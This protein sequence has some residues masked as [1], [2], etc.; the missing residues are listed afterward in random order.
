MPM[1]KPAGS[2][3][4]ERKT[5]SSASPFGTQLKLRAS[6]A[7]I[8]AAIAVLSSG[9]ALAADESQDIAE[10]R[11][12]NAR[13]RQ[14]LEA[15]RE[16]ARQAKA[17]LAPA[18]AVAPADNAAAKPATAFKAAGADG[19]VAFDKVVITS[20][21]R[22]EIAQ[23][24]PLPIQVIGGAQLER[25]DVKSVWDLP[26]KAPNLR[27]NP[28]GENA[29]K[30]S[31]S[32]RGVG[33]NGA[34]DSAEGS[35][36]TIVDG[37]SLYYAGQ[38]WN[39]YVDLDRIEVLRGPQG[40]LMGKNTTL[41]AVN[42]VTKAPSFTPS[43]SFEVGTG[44]LNSLQGKFSATGPL[45]DGLLAY[46]GTFVVDRA[47]GLYTNTYQ[48]FGNAKE[49]WNETNRLAGRFQFLLTPS[50]DLSARFIFDKLRSDE[51]TNL[52]FQWDNGPNTWSDGVARSSVTVPAGA[53]GSFSRIGYLGKFTQRSAWF[54]NSDGTVYQPRLGSTN[55]GNSEARPQITNQYGSSA[56]VDWQLKDHTLTSIT[57]YR[58]QDFDIKNGG[59]YDQ[60]YI[61]NSGQQLWNKQFSQEF[62][63]ASTPAADKALDY[64]VGLYYLKARVYSDDPTY[65][66]ADAGAWNASSKDY[67]TLIANAAGRE[68]LRASLDGIYQSSVTDARVRSVA[69][70]GQADWHVTEQATLTAGVR[71]T[72]EHK[73]NRIS[74]QL[75]RPGQ[76]LA[77]LA[78]ANGAS[79]AQ[80]AAATATRNGQVNT[81]FDF[82][83]GLPI[84]DKLTAWNFGPSYK[85]SNDILLYSSVGKGVKSGIVAWKSTTDTT[86]SNLES[87]KSLDFEL[88]FK[89]LLLDRKVQFNVNLYQTKITDYQTQVSVLQSD[90]VT[91]K[92]IWLNAPGVKARGLE[93]EAAYQYSNRLSFSANG[94]Y[95]LA[96][97]DGE[98]RV[99]RPDVDTSLP[100]YAGLNGTVDLNGKQLY[101]APKLSFNLGVN[102]QA[103]IAGYLGRVTLNNSYVSGTYLAVNQAAFSW[104]EGYNVTNL[105]LGLG[106]LDRKYELSLIGK[107]IFDKTYATSKGTYT[108]TGAET[109]QLGAPR[110]WGVIFRSKF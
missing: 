84:D 64:Q 48:S 53:S 82:V 41:G 69:G 74:Q 65:Y 101:Q 10:L 62:R 18:T 96:T 33:R 73:T 90:G 13:L 36:A 89:S 56:Q 35:V 85:L 22:E 2:L 86:P 93:L 77:T 81:P 24:V 51:R 60:F 54:K 31:I 80:L 3:R 70:Y 67:N 71:E 32:I 29:R 19:V 45:V 7:A 39:D 27:L 9:Q 12:E 55:F 16:A 102:Y 28:P 68:L 44:N 78:A 21:N 1:T 5:P 94:A 95:N 91:N 88:G 98:F 43:S 100:Q 40:T 4:R 104:Q 26:G 79:A 6:T 11:A 42:I 57:A 15:T 49:T 110:F 109:L 92:S 17:G 66:G 30:V 76:N 8:M 14:E 20:R 50:D 106:S 97:Y 87:E 63:L 38:A 75:D 59:N 83:D 99:A 34:N 52:G 108:S 23:N 47:N 37:V 107:N 25:D 103:P 72:W 61:G 105:G 46:R 58:Y